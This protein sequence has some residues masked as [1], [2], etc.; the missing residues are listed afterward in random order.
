MDEG[1][2]GKVVYRA[3]SPGGGEG[4]RGRRWAGDVGDCPL[5]VDAG[6]RGIGETCCAMQGYAGREREILEEKEKR[7]RKKRNGCC[8]IG[9]AGPAAGQR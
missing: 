9:D 2:G 6:K 7:E 3:I 4:V 5:S 1:E 8:G